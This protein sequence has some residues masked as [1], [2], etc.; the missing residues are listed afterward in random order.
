VSGSTQA[1]R[2]LRAKRSRREGA[3]RS[4]GTAVERVNR[5][6]R[7]AG[8]TRKRERTVDASALFVA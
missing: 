8:P 7:E 1:E 4:A 2:P 3:P 6:G 5:T